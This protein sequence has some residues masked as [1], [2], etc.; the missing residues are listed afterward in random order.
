MT[1]ELTEEEKKEFT[2]DVSPFIVPEY[3]K[4]VRI[5]TFL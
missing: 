1:A 4:G 3:P 2:E 5:H